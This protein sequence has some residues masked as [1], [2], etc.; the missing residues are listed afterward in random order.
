MCRSWFAVHRYKTH[1]VQKV[2]KSGIIL[3]GI[4]GGIYTAET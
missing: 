4:K 3:N 1:F 2:K